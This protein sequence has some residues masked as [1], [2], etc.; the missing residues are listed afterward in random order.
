MR[1]YHDLLRD[2]L[3]NGVR[4]EDR[5]G[6]GTVSVFGRQFRHNLADGFPL[7]TTK[8]VHL[9]SIINE[10]I[11]FLNGDTNVAW[12]QEHGVS[13]W[14]EWATDTGDL[15]PVYGKQWRAW[16]TR[17][18]GEID[19]IEYVLDCLKNRPDSRRILFHA[20]NVEYLPDESLSPQENALAGRMALPPCHLLYQFYV[21]EGRLS[22]QLYIRSSD[23]FLG[24]PFNTASL[25]VL[26]MMLAQQSDL[27]P[28]EIIVS[29]GD[30]HLYLNH[31]EQ[32]NEQL[33]REP[34]PLPKLT[35]LRKPESIYDYRFEDF[36]LSDYDPHPAIP[37]PVSV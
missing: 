11:W 32:V 13:I 21:A 27:E 31:M 34:R 20:W 5:T 10:L 22:A 17:D 25:A 19:Q 29:T 7:L 37:A 16:P 12:L 28:G 26:V 30:S 6:T 4:K 2:I 36:E 1:Q 23:T 18:G 33:S 8:K 15:G 14:N 3:D 24:L 35:L 9:R